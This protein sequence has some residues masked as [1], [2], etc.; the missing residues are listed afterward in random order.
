MTRLAVVVFAALIVIGFAGGRTSAA[1]MTD[2]E[3]VVANHST[4]VWR[5]HLHNRP[6]PPS[7]S[8]TAQ[9]DLSMDAAAPTATTLHNYATDLDPAASG[10]VLRPSNLGADETAA[11]R[12][13]NWRSDVMSSTRRIEG[14][15][16]VELWSALRAYADGRGVLGVY[17]RDYDPTTGTSTAIASVTIDQASWSDGSADFVQKLVEVPVTAYDIPVGHQLELK[18][19]AASGSADDLWIAYDTVTHQSSVHLP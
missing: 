15:L 19:V 12:Y 3:E 11:D 7:G 2:T 5:Y 8:T 13:V 16:Q 14:T 1:L 17:V 18:L 4:D 9:V 10:R 6:S